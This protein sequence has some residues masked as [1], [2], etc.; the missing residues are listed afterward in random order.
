[1]NP[2][3]FELFGRAIHW[4]GIIIVTCIVIG[5]YLAMRYAKNLGF[6]PDIILDFALLAIPMAVIFS[7]VFYVIFTLET[8]AYNPL[9]AFKIWEGGL[10]IHGAVIGGALAGIVFTKWKKIKYSVLADICAPSVI[11]GQAIG[12]WGNF[13]NQEAYGLPITDP[14]MQWFPFA[15][16]IEANQQ[17]QMATF[18]YESMWNFMVFGLLIWFKPKRK[19]TGEVFLIYMIAYSIGR[20]VIEGFRMDSLMLAGFRVAQL[21]SILLILVGTSLFILRRNNLKNQKIN[22]SSKV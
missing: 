17:W 7:R 9:D 2:V 6:N 1:M 10:S 14:N 21:L 19:A 3:A 16:F 20:F 22:L 13:F 8:Y 15:V 4:Y 18:F 11:L 5:T 12:R